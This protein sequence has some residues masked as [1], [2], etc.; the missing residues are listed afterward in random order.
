MLVDV[1]AVL[2]A[3]LSPTLTAQ[4]YG[5]NMGHGYILVYEKQ[6]PAS[7]VSSPSRSAAVPPSR[8]PFSV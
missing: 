6:K 4:E 3:R 5:S 8:L 7:A 2:F 1:S